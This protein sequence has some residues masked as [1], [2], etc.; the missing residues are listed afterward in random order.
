MAYRRESDTTYDKSHWTRHSFDKKQLHTTITKYRRATIGNRHKL[1]HFPWLINSKVALI[2]DTPP[3]FTTVLLST[4]TLARGSMEQP[5]KRQRTSRV[6]RRSSIDNS[7]SGGTEKMS[8]TGVASA[9]FIEDHNDIKNPPFRGPYSASSR[10]TP[11][12]AESR[13]KQGRPIGGRSALWARHREL[14]GGQMVPRQDTVASG[15]IKTVI[16]SVVQVVVENG[17][18]SVGVLTLPQ[19]PT[20]VPFPS[21][22]PLTVPAVPAYPSAPP[23]TL[24][25]VPTYPFA[26]TA[27]ALSS[28]AA[29]SAST[30]A[31][32]SVPSNAAS[33]APSNI[34]SSAPRI[35]GTSAPAIAP[36]FSSALQSS[37]S[38]QT[39]FSR[40]KPLPSSSSSKLPTSHS[41][42]QASSVRTSSEFPSLTAAGNFS[43]ISEFSVRIMLII[44]LICLNQHSHILTAPPPSQPRAQSL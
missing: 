30:N 6:F 10:D 19:V 4:W 39:S 36:E 16:Q 2:E 37:N 22:G 11:E 40:S 43:M 14:H 29:I 21:Y 7:R 33:S 13:L 15:P 17:Q 8:S 42:A 25:T 38:S 20:V 26:T 23:Q 12:L 35:A 31:A 41:S 28:N 27:T 1:S 5:S 3:S 24:P 18:S 44:L 9:G 32:P 34:A